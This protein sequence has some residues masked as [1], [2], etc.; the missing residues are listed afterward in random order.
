[1]FQPKL[2]SSG[3]IFV[4]FNKFYYQVKNGDAPERIEVPTGVFD[5]DERYKQLEHKYFITKDSAF[6]R[7]K[8]N[9]SNSKILPTFSMSFEPNNYSANPTAVYVM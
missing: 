8:E 3:T 9:I 1:M 7:A 5:T 6:A 4:Y 2:Y